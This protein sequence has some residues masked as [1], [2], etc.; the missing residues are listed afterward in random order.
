LT[1]SKEERTWAIRVILCFG[2]VSLFADMTYEG[3][4][5]IVGP[6]LK[7]LGATAGQVGVIAGLGEMVAASLRLFSG[8]FADRTRAYWGISILGYALNL[9]VVPAMAFAGNWQMAAL[10]VVAERTGKALRGPA[11]DVLL[12]EATGKVGHGF[13]FGVHAAMDQT[14]AVIGP[15]MMAWAVAKANHFGPAFLRLAFPAAA[16]LVALILAHFV[17]QGKGAPAPKVVP[18]QVL[19]KV[20]WIYVAAAGVLACG[21]VDFPLLA[22]HFQKTQLAKPAVIPLLYA[23]AMGMNGIT[24]LVLGKMYDR[25]GIPI[26]S[27]GILISMLALPLGFLGGPAGA[28]AS[29][30][31]WGVGLGAQDASLRSGIAQVVSM[32]KRGGAF[33]AFNGVYG[34]AWFVGSATMGLLYDHSVMAL[35]VFGVVMQLVAAGMF[36]WLRRPLAAAAAAQ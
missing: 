11:R 36:F 7:D 5:S 26:L 1:V 9:I 31:C 16:A 15:L 13:G 18:Q 22:Y 14:G 23:G 6:F 30:A 3:A 19:P 27:F 35:V 2:L 34:V 4:H 17:Y 32:N 10:L 29:V 20:F 28:I 33:G 25:F 8:R 12:S 21:F 24:A